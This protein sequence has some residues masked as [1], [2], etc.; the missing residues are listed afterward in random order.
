MV[1]R[2]HGPYGR[3]RRPRYARSERAAL[4]DLL[5]RVGPAEPTLCAGW[6][7]ADLAAHLVTRERRPDAS[8]GLVVNRRAGYAD[9]VRRG[10]LARNDFDQL[11]G[12]VRRWPPRWFPPAVDEA[13][14]AL[15]FFVHHEDVRR[16]RGGWKPRDLSPDHEADLWRRLTGGV[17]V[18]LRP[19]QVRVVLVSPLGMRSAGARPATETVTVTG[20]APELVMFA[21]GRQGHARVEFGGPQAAVA[22]VRRLHLGVGGLSR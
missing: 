15:E 18:L 22:A 9:S 6:N 16:A 2:Q 7:T 3:S 20:R 12:L 17:R 8:L 21:F 4:C 1:P 19:A 13:M 14:N 10:A 11:I 5:A